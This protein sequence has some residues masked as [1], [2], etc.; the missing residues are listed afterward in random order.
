VQPAATASKQ[1]VY[2]M[3][4][5]AIKRVLVGGETIFEDGRLTRV[6]ESAIVAK[7]REVTKGWEVPS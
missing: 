7:V 5:E 6:D 4:P 2:A 1:I 3:Q